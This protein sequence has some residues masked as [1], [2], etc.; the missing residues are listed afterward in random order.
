MRLPTTPVIAVRMASISPFIDV[1]MSKRKYTSE[2]W[3]FVR[4]RRVSWAGMGGSA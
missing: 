1:V 3:M 2:N 4:N